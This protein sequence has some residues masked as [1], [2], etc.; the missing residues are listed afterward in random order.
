MRSTK[1]IT[2]LKDLALL[3]LLVLAMALPGLNGL[4]VIDRDEAR[5]AQA[6]AQM[7]ET[8]DYI[9]IRF[10]DQARNKK[11]AGAYWAQAASVNMFSS[12]E[13]REIWAYR[14]PSVLA[15]L[16]AVF[17][18]YF[19][20]IRLLGRQSA[21]IG[22]AL[23]AVSMIFVFEAHIAKTDA[24]LC[25]FT[26]LA[27]AA[28][29][30]LRNPKNPNGKGRLAAL[31]FW[32]A[33]GCAVMVKGPLLP[34][35]VLL[36]LISLW[37]WERSLVWAKPLL[38]WLGPILFLAIVT[39][40]MVMIWQE[41]NGAFF[42]DALGGDLA[43]KL[44]GGHETH[45]G[46]P[47]FYTVFTNLTFWPGSL[48]LLAGLGF[49]WRAASGK[50]KTAVIGRSARFL[51]SWSL[52]FFI[53]LEIIPTK[54]PHY[55]LPVYPAFA[56]M[57]GAAIS[58]L[59]R[60]DEFKTMRRIGAGLFAVFSTVLVAGLL[61]GEAYYGEFP[62]FT[63][64]LL[65]LGLVGCYY[66]AIKFWNGQ[67]V[68]AFWSSLVAAALISIPTYALTLPSLN[69]L[70]LAGGVKSALADAG[71]ETPNTDINIYSPQISEPSFVFMLGT[72][73]TVAQ[74]EALTANAVL[75]PNDI[76][77]FENLRTDMDGYKAKVESVHELAGI[78]LKPMT[79][80]EGTNYANGDEVAL[81]VNRAVVCE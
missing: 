59:S 51:L 7:L 9:N 29:A 23:L 19:G 61:G 73:I 12:V 24:L 39:P 47:G 49:A 55:P 58:A 71:I 60:L 13:A 30:N 64:G 25:G 36:T 46:P 80:V 50:D 6:S 53:L 21:V 17:A 74:S 8:G 2:R 27:F 75:K 10:Q 35:L 38:F 45:G 32:F 42:K 63:F 62:T 54:L 31:V 22:A 68:K 65:G 14:L 76:V 77:I 26:A 70:A 67:S 81:E 34:L 11:P 48:F 15:A 52:P 66:A 40:W 18:T 56:L 41:T 4:P 78:C 3:A 57:C 37:V 72:D 79:T 16:L 28:L 69:S 33:I 5:Y 1:F 20:G 43:P 44:K